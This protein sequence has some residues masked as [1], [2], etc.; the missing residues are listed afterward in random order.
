VREVNEAA[1]AI[2]RRAAAGRPVLVA[3]GI[4]PSGTTVEPFGEVPFEQAVAMFREQ[5]DALVRSG[6]DPMAIETMFDLTEAKAA[7]IA[8]RE[9]AP[10]LPIVAHLTF[11][12]R[13]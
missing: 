6:A 2:A 3:G 12:P 11:G 4:G 10:V 9:T 5:A 13:A 8:V 1:V 7:L